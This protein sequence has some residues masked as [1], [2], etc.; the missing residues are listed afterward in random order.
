MSSYENIST[1]T[2]GA[3]TELYISADLLSK[4]YE[5]FRA[6]SPHC[7]ADLVIYKNGKIQRVE[8]RTAYRHKITK[9]LLFSKRTKHKVDLFATFIPNEKSCKYFSAEGGE[10]SKYPNEYY[11]KDKIEL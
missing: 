6:L 8:C 4:G 9:V 2:V 1:G 7:G 3:L 10:N 5:V 11:A